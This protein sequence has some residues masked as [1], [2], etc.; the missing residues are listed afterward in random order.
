MERKSKSSRTTL[1]V[2]SFIFGLLVV[3]VAAYYICV[4]PAPENTFAPYMNYSLAIEAEYRFVGSSGE[5]LFAPIHAI[6]RWLRPDTWSSEDWANQFQH[7]RK[8]A[9]IERSV[10]VQ[11]ED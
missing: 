9:E 5:I 6:D 11:Y 8:A 1:F 4:Q 10:G 7:S 3:Y 2:L